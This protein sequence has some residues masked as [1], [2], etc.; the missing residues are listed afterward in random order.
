MTFWSD[1][2][3]TNSHVWLVLRDLNSSFIADSHCFEYL[4]PDAC[5][6]A[7]AGSEQKYGDMGVTQIFWVMDGFIGIHG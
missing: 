4:P 2:R 6:R 7:N 5:L 1:G 3:G